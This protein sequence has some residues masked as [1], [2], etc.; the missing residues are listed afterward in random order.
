MADFKHGRD[1]QPGEFYR[2]GVVNDCEKY[3]QQENDAIDNSRGVR[4]YP[5]TLA[6]LIDDIGTDISYAAFVRICDPAYARRKLR[7]FAKELALR[8]QGGLSLDEVLR[9]CNQ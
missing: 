3:H 1:I 2:P 4:Q 6:G 5:L 9:E 8:V 7:V